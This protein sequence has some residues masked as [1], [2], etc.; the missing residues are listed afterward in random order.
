[1]SQDFYVVRDLN[2]NK[3]LG[4]YWLKNPCSVWIYFDLECFNIN[5]NTL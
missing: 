4:L 5:G 3:I 1:M 2:R